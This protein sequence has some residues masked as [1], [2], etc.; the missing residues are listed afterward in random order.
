VRLEQSENQELIEEIHRVFA[1]DR[2]A[3]T[4]LLR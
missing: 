1:R 3:R 2:A 4:D